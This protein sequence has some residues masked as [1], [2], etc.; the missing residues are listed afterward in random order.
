MA[1]ELWDS[2]VRVT[3]DPDGAATVLVQYG[4][5]M[6]EPVKVDGKQVVQEGQGLK[7]AGVDNFPRGNER[8]ELRFTLARETPGVADAF[9]DRLTRSLA[10]PRGKGDIRLSFESGAQFRLRKC[11]IESWPHDQVEHLIKETLVIR[12]GEMVQEGTS[13]PDPIGLEAALLNVTGGEGTIDASNA[14]ASQEE[15]VKDWNNRGTGSKLTNATSGERPLLLDYSG[16]FL[17]GVSG[18]YAGIPDHAVVD[19]AVSF[20]VGV[21][22]RLPSYRPASQVCLASKWTVAGNQRSWRLLLNTNGTVTIE[23]STDGTAGTI[24]SRTSSVALPL[25][26]W[27]FLGL[28]VRRGDVFVEFCLYTEE[29]PE[30]PIVT[31][32]DIFSFSPLV[33]APFNSSAPVIIGGSDGGT[34]DLMHGVVSRYHWYRDSA[35]RDWNG[36]T[37]RVIFTSGADSAATQV[38]QI[39][40]S[41]SVSV[42]PYLARSGTNSARMVFNPVL[43]FDGTDDSLAMATP[44]AL[45]AVPGITLAWH[46]TLNTVSGPQALFYAADNGSGIRVLLGANGSAVELHVT[47][48]DGEMVAVISFAGAFTAFLPELVIAVVDYAAGIATI[49]LDG[50]PKVSGNLT[51]AGATSSATNSTETRIMAGDGGSNPARGEV[52]AVYLLDKVT[53]FSQVPAL[54]T[55]LL[56]QSR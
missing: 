14:P 28:H 44:A 5:P 17:P 36:T 8:H 13:G 39:L 7:R 23:V 54:Y 11:A 9:E 35:P 49:Y 51:S 21:Y 20:A 10:V 46:G 22:C 3:W 55:T 29:D 43:R 48:V 37:G 6:W 56:N 26:P 27:D 32:G 45:N 4:D 19:M 30:A 15:A 12:C 2:V 24:W 34:V 40:G 16:L 47:R 53:P 18:N 33:T 38:P 50:Q 41:A 52:N 31:L 42:T 1:L 25:A